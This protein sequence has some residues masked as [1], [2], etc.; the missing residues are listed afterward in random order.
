MLRPLGRFCVTSCELN[1]FR[2]QVHTK[3]TQ[4]GLSVYTSDH[5]R[6][7]ARTVPA[8]PAGTPR[9][10]QPTRSPAEEKPRGAELR[11]ARGAGG[12]SAC[13]DWAKEVPVTPEGPGFLGAGLVT[14]RAR[15]LAGPAGR[16]GQESGAPRLTVGALRGSEE[17]RVGAARAGLDAPGERPGLVV[18]AQLPRT[19]PPT[20][21]GPGPGQSPRSPSHRGPLAPRS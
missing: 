18:T 16:G 9:G 1:S 11:G 12:R 5:S 2:T 7:S 6:D 13:F 3:S 4:A 17:T 8:L 10:P 14:S 15:S 21:L 19:P 20:P